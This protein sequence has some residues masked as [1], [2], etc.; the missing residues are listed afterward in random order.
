MIGV[1]FLGLGPRTFASVTGAAVLAVVLVVALALRAPRRLAPPSLGRPL[2][3]F[4]AAI[5]ALAVSHGL[6]LLLA[7]ARPG[8]F[9]TVNDY[10]PLRVF[11]LRLAFVR[12]PD[13]LF[14][15][16][17]VAA[18]IIT[19]RAAASE[20]PPGGWRLLGLSL[21]L[22]VTLNASQ[23]GIEAGLSGGVS[24]P[25]I[26]DQMYDD[27]DGLPPLRDLLAGF[28]DP[29]TIHHW[30]SPHTKSHPPLPLALLGGARNLG[31]PPLTVGLLLLVIASAAPCLA[32]LLFRKVTP[33]A[34]VGAGRLAALLA[35][36][37]AVNIYGGSSLEGPFLTL[38][39]VV[40][41]VF[42]PT[43]A[44]PTRLR[45]FLAGIACTALC[46]Y[47]FGGVWLLA[48]LPCLGSLARPRYF[49]EFRGRLVDAALFLAPM[50]A[51]YAYLR[52]ACSYDYLRHL[53]HV[54]ASV[55]G[56]NW[57][58]SPLL[59]VESRMQNVGE[60]LLLGS[61]LLLG[62]WLHVLSRG[63]RSGASAAAGI[64][65]SGIPIALLLL[66]TSIYSEF[67]RG[68]LLLAPFLVLPCVPWLRRRPAAALVLASTGLW[69]V[70][71]QCLGDFGW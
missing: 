57:F 20:A 35:L 5:A 70:L 69:T 27:A 55:M 7:Q 41:V 23:G 48:M 21:L 13:L 40:A 43:R 26:R 12:W 56:V 2:R 42:T 28:A 32:L 59:V 36:S 71:W 46:L 58:S 61:P 51:A 37:P 31:L 64:A 39:L 11:G 66:L 49:R 38:A 44:G 34:P 47:S 3:A 16:L 9:Y 54:S 65:A 4:L 18:V 60:L 68:W 24:T 67:A 53:S 1:A 52:W 8:L 63:R 29:D 33:G 6:F 62:A 45:A 15:L 14:L 50:V 25:A 10:W 22:L 30:R 17:G 19:V